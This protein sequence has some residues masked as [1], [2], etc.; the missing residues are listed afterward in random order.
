MKRDEGVAMCD[1]S[2]ARKNAFH[3][4]AWSSNHEERIGARKMGTAVAESPSLEAGQEEAG[5]MTE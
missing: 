5:R 3:H 2:K 4:A 1:A